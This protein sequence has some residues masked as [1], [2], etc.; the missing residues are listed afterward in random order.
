[1]NLSNPLTI[2]KLYVKIIL[3]IVIFSISALAY[4]YPIYKKGY[5]SGA[6]YLNL[7]EARNFA[8]SGTL[9][10]ESSIGM[11]LSSHNAGQGVITGVPN[12]LTPIIY[13]YIFKYLG[14]NTNL[15]L[16]TSILLLSIFNVLLFLIVEK[17]FSIGTGLVA[18]LS[19]AFMPIMN[20]AATNAGFYE[21]GMLFFAIAVWLF[22]CSKEGPLKSSLIRTVLASVFFALAALARNAFAISFIP[23][24]LMDFFINKSF[25]RSLIFFLPFLIIFGSTL[26]PYSWLPAPNGYTKAVGQSF[27]QIGH[28]FDDPYSYYFNKEN[29]LAEHFPAGKSLNRVSVYYFKLYG[30]SVDLK[31]SFLAYIDA[32]KF[33]IGQFFQIINIGGPAILLLIILGGWYLRKKN[34]LLL[35]FFSLWFIVW[36]ICLVLDKTGNWDHY[37]EI[38]IPIITLC[39][40]GFW[41]IADLI[42]NYLGRNKSYIAILGLLFLLIVQLSQST[43]WR[44]H[45]DYRSSNIEPVL[46]FANA[47]K[48]NGFNAPY[49]MDIH[50]DA[51]YALNY[52]TDKDVIYFNADTVK[53]LLGSKKLHDA[54]TAYNVKAVLGYP[55]DVSSLISNTMQIPVL[56]WDKISK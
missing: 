27:S 46:Q 52:Y 55:S 8:L 9:N 54:F 15:P 23:F 42:K 6:D 18:G 32:L 51:A 4:Y 34:P 1:M 43:K 25:K 44:L 5:P 14:F 16:Y 38:I 45:D 56:S 30:Y 13:G 3:S 28:V 29:F 48:Q 11:F 21:W 53:E 41:N 35:K 19:S 24:L 39:A 10:S 22:L 50:P 33:Y 40:Y 2:K 47:L 7:I 26:T 37:L 17:L 49:A 36:L 12:P 31:S 20:I